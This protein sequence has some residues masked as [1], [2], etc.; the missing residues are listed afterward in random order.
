MVL[1]EAPVS[2]CS[3]LLGR[4]V[5]HRHPRAAS[6]AVD[7][8]LQ[9]GFAPAGGPALPEAVPVATEDLLVLHELLPRDVGRVDALQ[10]D[11]PVLQWTRMDP[12]LAIGRRAIER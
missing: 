4:V 2:R 10:A 6:A 12:G 8:P 3:L 7:D 11:R 9:Q 1:I 5:Q